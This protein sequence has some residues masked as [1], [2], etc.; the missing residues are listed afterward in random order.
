MKF[1]NGK[2]YIIDKG[3]MNSGEVTLISFSRWFC[4]VR[5]CKTGNEWETMKARLSIIDIKEKEIE[6]TCNY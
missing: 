6:K 3:C 2:Q 4:V 1:E 5:D